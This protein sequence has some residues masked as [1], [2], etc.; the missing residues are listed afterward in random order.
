MGTWSNN[1]F[2][3]N[4]YWFYILLSQK[5]RQQSS[6]YLQLEIWKTS[7][8]ASHCYLFPPLS[9]LSL[10]DWQKPTLE[11]SWAFPGLQLSLWI[12]HLHL[13]VGHKSTCQTS[14]IFCTHF[15]ASYWHTELKYHTLCPPSLLSNWR[16][17]CTLNRSSPLK[18]QMTHPQPLPCLPLGKTIKYLSL[19]APG[20]SLVPSLFLREVFSIY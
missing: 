3:T 18:M 13:P 16:L 6:S 1:S 12:Q 4:G 19:W 5:R 8:C 20:F 7:S 9:L 11:Q 15:T 17:Q 2:V 10:Q 14:Q